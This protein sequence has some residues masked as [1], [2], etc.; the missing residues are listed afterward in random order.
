MKIAKKIYT[1]ALGLALMSSLTACSNDWLDVAPTSGVAAD[2]ALRTANDLASARIGM[3][4]ALK[5]TSSQVDYY[6]RNMFVYGEVR[7]EDVQYDETNG[8]NRG[9]FYYK[10]EY[11]NADEFGQENAVWQSPLITIGRANRIIEAADGTGITDAADNAAVIAQYKNEAKVVRAMCLFDL[12]RV[13]GQPYLKD[14]GASLGAPMAT[15]VFD[16][17]I[18]I[19]RSS[20]AE[21]YAQVIKDLT[22]AISSGAL[23]TDKTPGY[24]NKWAAEALLSRV[25]LTQGDYAH[26]LS[27]AEDV[28][29]NSPYQLW[30]RDQYV[31]AW[32]NKDAN[33]T[34]ELLFEFSIT[35]STDWV[36]R[37]GYAYMTIE[38]SHALADPGYGDILITKSFS[39]SLL[40]DAG[41]IRNDIVTEATDSANNARFLGR[42]VYLK[43]F[44]DGRYNNVPV[45]R[46]S[47]VYLNAAEAAF[48]LG[49][50]ANAAKYL[51]AIISNRTTSATTVTAETVTAQ[52][53]YMERRKEL[54]GEGHRYFDALR[55][56]ETITR[57]TN[58]A[59]RG[60]HSVLNADARVIDTWH[61]KKALPLIP[62]YEMDANPAMQQNPEY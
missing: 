42:K 8:S 35:N 6:G 61:S 18:Q 37:E 29:N 10:M 22:E 39:D 56:G 7:G 15:K 28:I 31:S 53:I 13:Y 11:T 58:L 41:D 1:A 62:K 55:R 34:N 51:N 49:D 33:H 48:D 59:N 36:D 12:T 40:T 2:G 27:A 57:Y 24:I 14:K 47:E 19:G 5:G 25:Y 9:S 21:C 46:L 16:S 38:N 54:V 32:A 17:N 43:K 26:A 60:W 30:T 20:V 4:K 52:R 45:L 23:A 44:P 3:Y 50:K